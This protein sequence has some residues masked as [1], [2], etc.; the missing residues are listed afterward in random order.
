MSMHDNINLKEV[1]ARLRTIRAYQ[2]KT[3]S[4]MAKDLGISLSH[5]S[6]L[7]IGI[8]GMSHGLALALCR[9]FEISEDWLLH[10]IGP[11]PDLSTIRMLS[12]SPRICNTYDNSLT[13]DDLVDIMDI[14]AQPDFITLAERV[15]VTMEISVPRAMAML[16]R[17]K[18]RS[19]KLSL[20]SVTPEH[21][22]VQNPA[23]EA[24]DRGEAEA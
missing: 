16:A 19:N 10:G 11:Q 15:A 6:K 23:G 22:E 24:A 21:E 20:A 12:R 5:Y 17:E 13:E 14:V 7:E 1:G 18:M 2:R 4:N 9:Q 3:Q 8:G